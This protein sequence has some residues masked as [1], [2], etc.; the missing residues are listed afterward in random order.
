MLSMQKIYVSFVQLFVTNV[1]RIVTYS[2][3]ITAK[4]VLIY[5][6]TVP[7]NADRFCSNY[8]PGIGNSPIWQ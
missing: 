8:Y 5:A 7:M 2:K 4:N 3:M 1:L 6:V